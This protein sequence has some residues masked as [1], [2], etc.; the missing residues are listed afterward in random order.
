M[1][2]GTEEV[3]RLSLRPLRRHL[4]VRSLRR[5]PD[6]SLS[7]LQFLSDPTIDKGL[8][9]NPTRAGFGFQ[10]GVQ[11]RI[12]SD[13]TSTLG[14]EFKGDLRRLFGVV[15]EA[16]RIPKRSNLFQSTGLRD[17]R[18]SLSITFVHGIVGLSINSHTLDGHTG[19]KT[20]DLECEGRGPA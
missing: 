16:V 8:R 13:P 19:A 4:A 15:G 18:P 20:F 6:R 5:Q 2:I 9:R 17:G 11:F 12:E 14:T 3:L 1:S 10:S 7:R